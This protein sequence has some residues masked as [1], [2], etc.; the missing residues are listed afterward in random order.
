MRNNLNRQNPRL[1]P[2]QNRTTPTKPSK[3]RKTSKNKKTYLKKRGKSID[4]SHHKKPPSTLFSQEITYYHN[5]PYHQPIMSLDK[6]IAQSQENAIHNNNT[7][8]PNIN[9]MSLSIS[10]YNE[11]SAFS[12]SPTHSS[13]IIKILPP[14][15][16]EFLNKKTLLLDLDE[17]LVHSCFSQYNPNIP[18]D[19]IL[20]I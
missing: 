2:P 18:S 9:L 10:Q 4:I 13:Q 7:N 17:T 1:L 6:M 3:S 16:E 5:Q 15:S 19:I 14:K 11:R 12:V 20:Q 8:N